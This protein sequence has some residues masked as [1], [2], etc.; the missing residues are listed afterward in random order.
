MHAT[1]DKVSQMAGPSLAEAVPLDP[2]H[3]AVMLNA[4]ARRVTNRVATQMAAL[5]GKE[6]LFHSHSLHEA[7]AFARQI[8]QRGYGT[9]VCGGGDGTLLTCYNHIQRYIDEA[10][11][12][13]VER[14]RRYGEVQRPLVAPRLAFLS[15][16]TGNGLRRVVGAQT[17][18]TD[19]RTIVENRAPKHHEISL[20]QGLGQ[21]FTFGGFG[22]DSMLLN[23]YNCLRAHSYN[24]L[25]RPV[26]QSVLGYF[27]AVFTRTLPRALMQT[28]LQARI[29]ARSPSYFV[30]PRRGDTVEPLP[31]NTV[32][33]EGTVSVVG[34]G[35]TP[36][37]GYG[38]KF[39]PFAGMRP[40]M[41]HLRVANIPPLTALRALPS[42]W[43]G[44]YRNPE[45]MFDF[46]TDSLEI[47]LSRPFPFQQSGDDQGVVDKLTLK[48]ATQRLKLVDLYT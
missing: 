2:Q 39:F 46:L 1:E 18:L 20:I 17:P 35:T 29:V 40:G 16:G 8:V 36:F 5:V 4:N 42:V 30:D 43:R 28:P 23:D 33:H 19:L 44:V 12:W 32:L 9:V 37:F 6:N 27:A 38:M 26:L 24:P 14:F 41:M 47:S 15:L 22:Y 25:L 45:A 13:R 3:V 21:Y 48:I 11:R 7:E 10:N 31:A 34:V